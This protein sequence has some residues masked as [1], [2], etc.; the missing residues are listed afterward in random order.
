M[1]SRY[2]CS[3]YRSSTVLTYRKI[4]V[5]L[6][7]LKQINYNTVTITPNFFSVSISNIDSY[8]Y[9][10]DILANGFDHIWC[11]YI[12]IESIRTISWGASYRHEN[13][14]NYFAAMISIIFWTLSISME[15]PVESCTRPWEF[16]FTNISMYSA[17]EYCWDKLRWFPTPS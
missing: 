9:D 7:S 10:N 12:Y 3:R 5:S 16:V 17:T 2:R 1:Y 8:I 6:S 14:F 11:V 13:T 4:K 15:H